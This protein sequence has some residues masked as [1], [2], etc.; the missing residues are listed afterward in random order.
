MHL[1]VFGLKRLAFII[2]CCNKVQHCLDAVRSIFFFLFW[3]NDPIILFTIPLLLVLW[4]IVLQAQC[5]L[6]TISIMVL[7]LHFSFPVKCLYISN[8]LSNRSWSIPLLIFAISIFA[9][10]SLLLL[11]LQRH[12]RQILWWVNIR[13]VFAVLVMNNEKSHNASCIPCRQ[14]RGLH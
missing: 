3:V 9:V 2:S 1:I 10:H 12:F 5:F 8:L 13:Q 7:I 6:F 4:C 11:Y 14:A